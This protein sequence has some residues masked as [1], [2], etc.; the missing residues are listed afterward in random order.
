MRVFLSYGRPDRARVEQLAHALTGRGHAVWWDRQIAGGSAFAQEIERELNAADRVVV[1]WSIHSVASDWVRDEASDARDRGVLLPVL[2]DGTPAP[3][4]F[5]QYQ[6][7]DLSGWQGDPG[8]AEIEALSNALNGEALAPRPAAPTAP[9]P[10]PPAAPRPSRRFLPFA[11]IGVAAALVAAWFGLNPRTAEAQAQPH[12]ALGTFTLNSAGLPQGFAD[13]LRN[14]TL[15]AFG[16]DSRV[17]V[18][19]AET[20]R[21]DAWQ[22]SGNIVVAG[23]TLRVIAQLTNPATGAVIWTPRIERP[24]VELAVAATSI[25]ADMASGVRCVLRAARAEPALDEAALTLWGKFCAD[26]LISDPT[27]ALTQS[28]A[29]LERLTAAAPQFAAGWSSLAEL[30]TFAPSYDAAAAEVAARRALAITSNEPT[31]LQTLAAIAYRRFDFASAETLL[32]KAIALNSA[33][34]GCQ[35]THYSN[36]L[37]SIGRLREASAEMDKAIGLEP[38]DPANAL[39]RVYYAGASGDFDDADRRI[40]SLSG[41]V[42]GGPL[43]GYRFLNALLARR[44]TTLPALAAHS[45]DDGLRALRIVVAEAMAHPSPAAQGRAVAALDDYAHRADRGNGQTVSML[46]TMG[47]DA[48]ALDLL[49]K[50]VANHRTWTLTALYSPAGAR[51]RQTPAFE[52]VL[53]RYGILDYWRKS[54]KAPDFCSAPAAPPLCATLK[55]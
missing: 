33:D 19:L 15:A 48:R 50:A 38:L 5:R 46:L 47:E 2:L 36:V 25:G 27:A 42:M 51:M 43:A 31:G 4:G 23:D 41:R 1:A 44:F 6:A 11:G 52:A 12:V 21:K 17:D 39:T 45:E 20:G 22:L 34:C 54:R 8:A 13:Q 30:H 28:Q 26:A 24:R 18:A 35:H 16:T 7:V 10:T 40:A 29:S 14:E 53:K 9:A 3:L 55:R 37:A 32:Q 49:T